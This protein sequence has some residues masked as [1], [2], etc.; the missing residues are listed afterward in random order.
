MVTYEAHF[1]NVYTKQTT[2]FNELKWAVFSA[3][4]QESDLSNL[5]SQLQRSQQRSK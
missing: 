3:N 1:Y 5:V 2:E 4:M